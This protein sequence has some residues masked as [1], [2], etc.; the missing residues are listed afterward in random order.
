MIAPVPNPAQHPLPPLPP[1]PPAFKRLAGANWAAQ[2]AEQL[3][4]VATPIVAV[5]LLGA[6]AGEV[7]LLA[8][9]QT[10]PFLLLAMPLGVLAD[11]RSR[12]GLMV[13]AEWL[14][15]GSLVG[16]LLA[17]LSQHLS[18]PLLAALG[19][20]GAM[21]TVAFSVAAPALVPALVP[22][23]ALAQANGRL[24]LARSLAL[25]GGPALAGALVGWFGASAAF[26]LGAMLSAAAAIS[27]LGLRE[28]VRALAPARHPLTELREGAALVWHH[29]LLRP[30]ALTAVVWNLA[31]FVL[32][33]AYVPYAMRTLGLS[34]AGVGFT[35]TCQGVGMVVGALLARRFMAAVSYGTAIMLGPVLSFVAAACMAT[36][37][38]WPEPALVV[39]SFLLFGIGPIVWTISSTT[40]RQSVTPLAMLGRVSALLLTLNVGVRPFGALLG[41]AVGSAWGE[42]ACL[43][44]AVAGFALQALLIVLSPMRRLLQLPTAPESSSSATS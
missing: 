39:V 22:R 25:A 13:A 10:L 42:S 32:Q 19:F 11:R 41:G 15:T 1:L 16:L 14:R 31:W 8:A 27:L 6:G 20:L 24:E 34:A 23:E 36:T 37:I 33:S 7:G 43:L 9:A 21:G 5:Q 2:S 26:V 38:W 28:P 18:L 35:L 17:A 12:R 3:S 29:P 4:L 44:V 30:M 40:L